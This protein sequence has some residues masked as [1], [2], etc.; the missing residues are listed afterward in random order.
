MTRTENNSRNQEA[1]IKD[2][3]AAIKNL[4]NKFGQMAKLFS[5][6]PLGKFPSET[7]EPR[8]ENASAITT[9]SGKV[10]REVVE[11]KVDEKNE[12]GVEDKKEERKKKEIEKKRE[13]EIAEE[14]EKKENSKVPFPNSWMKKNLEKQ[15]SK[16]VSRVKKF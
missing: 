11:E 14:G 1:A 7:Q 12:D 15:L 8:M 4:E 16:F 3:Q 10:L 5:E 2:Q 9:R 6:R 13:K